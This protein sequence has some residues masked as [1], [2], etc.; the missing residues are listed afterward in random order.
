[1]QK[2][3]QDGLV[4]P[5]DGLALI[6]LHTGNFLF[7]PELAA[8]GKDIRIIAGDDKTPLKFFIE[9]VDA[10][11]EMALIWVKLPKEVVAAQD[12]AVWL[13]FN[14]P[15]AV[16][17]QDI[18]GTFNINQVLNYSFEGKDVKD[19]TANAT[20]PV[21]T[22]AVLNDGGL[23]GGS[24]TFQGTQVIRIPEKPSLAM[25]PTSGWTVSVWLKIEQSQSN[26]VLLQRGGNTSNQVALAIRDLTPVLEV[27]DVDGAK[28]EF[29]ASV[30][31]ATGSWQHLAV[32]ANAEKLALFLDGKSA[33]E[34][35]VKLA[36]VTG[37]MTIGADLSGNRGFSG[38]IDQLSVYKSA[39]DVN[40]V[41]YDFMMQ[42]ATG[43]L[44]TYGDEM[45]SDEESGGDE[46]YLL[47]TLDN[48]T[49]DGWVIIG[50]LGIM[51]LI[52][53]VVMIWKGITVNRI[54]KHN[55]LFE[56]AFRQ[57][58]AG[59]LSDLEHSQENIGKNQVNESPVLF[60]LANQNT[61]KE[62]SLYRIYHVGVD[63][64]EK[65][66]VKAVGAEVVA[67]QTLSA[68]AMEA[69]KASMHS[70]VVREL[71]KLNSMMV[72]LTIAIA[73]GPFLGLLGTVVGVMIT[74]AAIA[75]SGEI[76]VNAIAP[77]IAAALVA[78]VAG[79]FVAIPALFGYNYLGSKIK[80][81]SAD[82]Q[83]FVDEFVTK[84]AEEHT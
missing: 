80:V 16:D 84:L 75:A 74:F 34:F 31:L 79:L 53:W 73:G 7:F 42:G 17:G 30:N 29:T 24:A 65:R 82:M 40:A 23:I 22:T 6:R 8:G 18:P 66:F 57:L 50:I 63:E 39:R 12:A 27:W 19:S 21:Q 48:V 61:F 33:G 69:V 70:I 62:S 52:S 60:S 58:D 72:M 15:E 43:A 67:P 35:P 49:V 28:Q 37:D 5:E 38:A 46:S 4:A 2:V 78:T 71:Q 56:Q 25:S 13:Y 32:V 76:N 3:N 36:D 59:H 77:G 83:V 20:H 14:N 64:M 9:K 10:A 45:S 41:K 26:A 1:M 55:Q 81:V 47:S 44:L 11:N 54:L 51:S 68:S